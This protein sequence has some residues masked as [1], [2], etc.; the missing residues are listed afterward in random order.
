MPL[1]TG[2]IVERICQS[3]AGI[4]PVTVLERVK[5]WTRAGL[6]EPIGER[7]G[8]SGRHYRYLETV[9]VDVATLM[10][11]AD[12]GESVTTELRTA[13]SIVRE[14]FRDWDR[15]GRRSGLWLV[16]VY[17]GQP[18]TVT[19]NVYPGTPRFDP[20]ARAS[21][22]FN[23]AWEFRNVPRGLAAIAEWTDQM[24]ASRSGRR[25][26]GVRTGRKTQKGQTAGTKG[27]AK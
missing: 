13:L 10:I 16:L 7:S 4:K 15:A 3:G 14:S 18:P 19:A 11:V 23:L 6:L 1:S 17:A 12:T 8:G 21:K 25:A 26:Q 27:T 5:A 9:L 22:M 2:E 20:G 24:E